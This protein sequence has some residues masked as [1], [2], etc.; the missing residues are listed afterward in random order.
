MKTLYYKR[1]RKWLLFGSTAKFNGFFEWQYITM[2]QGF[3]RIAWKL[4][5]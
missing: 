3:I 5:V 2:L 1:T 4:F